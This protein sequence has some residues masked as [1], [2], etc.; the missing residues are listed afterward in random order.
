MQL[1]EE[2]VSNFHDW[3]DHQSQV[4]IIQNYWEAHLQLNPTN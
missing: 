4:M 2:V 1:H 3:K